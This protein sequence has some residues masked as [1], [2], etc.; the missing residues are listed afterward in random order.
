MGRRR[1]FGA[2]GDINKK[3]NCFSIKL[4]LKSY[5]VHGRIYRKIIK[6]KVIIRHV[7]IYKKNYTFS[8]FYKLLSKYLNLFD[9]EISTRSSRGGILLE[10]VPPG[11]LP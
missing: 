11:A 8:F 5:S 4:L 1:G 10:N 7:R 9:Y 2:S 3:V 6:V